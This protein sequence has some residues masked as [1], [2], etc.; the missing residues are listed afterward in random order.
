[1]ALDGATEELLYHTKSFFDITVMSAVLAVSLDDWRE[2]FLSVAAREIFQFDPTGTIA[3][4]G[5]DNYDVVLVGGVPRPQLL[6][7]S[8]IYRFSLTVEL[9]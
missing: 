8:Q 5:P 7:V 4:P 9:V 1:M 6:D 3:V 2:F